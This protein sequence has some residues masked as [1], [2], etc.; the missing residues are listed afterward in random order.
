MSGSVR[1]VPIWPSRLEEKQI[2]GAAVDVFDVEP[3]PPDHPWLGAPRL[4]VTPH[5]GGTSRE[6]IL[7]IGQAGI[8]NVLRLIGGE[9]LR[10]I[11]NAGA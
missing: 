6:A 2:A 11:V 7:R 1:S 5:L 3:P 8:D 4:Y 9:P 10:D